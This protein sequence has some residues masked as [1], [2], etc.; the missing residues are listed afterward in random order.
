MYA[1]KVQAIR[2]VNFHLNKKAKHW[3]S[4]KANPE[5]ESQSR[6]EVSC[7]YYQQRKYRL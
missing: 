3:R 5:A 6:L 1:G 4:W 2:G 7:D